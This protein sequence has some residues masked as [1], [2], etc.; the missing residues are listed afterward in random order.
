MAKEM[1]KQLLACGFTAEE[2]LPLPDEYTGHTLVLN[3]DCVRPE[4]R[5]RESLIWKAFGGFG[6]QKELIGRAVFAK[7]ADGENARWD[8]HDFVAELK[9]K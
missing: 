8:R 2:L 7:C 1:T 3:P 6:C 4:H 5:H 9:T